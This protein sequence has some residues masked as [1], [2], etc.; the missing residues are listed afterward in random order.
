MD[1]LDLL[2]RKPGLRQAMGVRGK[3]YAHQYF[4]LDGALVKFEREL[5][6]AAG[7]PLAAK[8]VHKVFDY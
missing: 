7:N 3:A 1:A 5:E 8:P 2:Y 6:L 4:S